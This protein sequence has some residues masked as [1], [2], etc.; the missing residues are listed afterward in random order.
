MLSKMFNLTKKSLTFYGAVMCVGAQST[1]PSF[2]L[3]FEEG[4]AALSRG[5]G[6]TALSRVGRDSV[7]LIFFD[8]KKP[9]LRQ[10]QSSLEQKGAIQLEPRRGQCMGTGSGERTP[11]TGENNLLTTKLAN[12]TNYTK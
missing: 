10:I 9:E 12:E 7:R 8:K 11:F 4:E 2:G 5:A 1:A 6:R 3:P